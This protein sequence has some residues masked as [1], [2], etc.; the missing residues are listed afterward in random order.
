MKQE[1]DKKDLIALVK[2]TIPNYG[3]MQNT[4]VKSNGYYIGGLG[5]SWHWHQDKLNELSESEL[6]ELYQLCKNS[7]K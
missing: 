5:D 1:L 2:G 7:F 6:W 4:L 3:I